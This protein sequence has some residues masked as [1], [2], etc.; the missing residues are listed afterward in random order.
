MMVRFLISGG[1]G[2]AHVQISAARC[3]VMTTIILPDGKTAAGDD[4]DGITPY[5]DHTP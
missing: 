4:I 2:L 3:I 5:V 1:E